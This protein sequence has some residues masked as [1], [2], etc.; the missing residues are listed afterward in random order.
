MS[1]T[2]KHKASNIG[3]L[4]RKRMLASGCKMMRADLC[5]QDISVVVVVRIRRS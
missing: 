1:K 5:K 3:I 4:H 2:N